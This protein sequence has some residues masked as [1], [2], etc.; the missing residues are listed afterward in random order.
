M[1][2]VKYKE[3][4]VNETS[5][6]CEASKRGANCVSWTPLTVDPSRI[7][8]EKKKKQTNNREK[9]INVD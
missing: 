6:K 8:K 9:G 1:Q 4:R 3:Y 5:F 2:I 7:Y